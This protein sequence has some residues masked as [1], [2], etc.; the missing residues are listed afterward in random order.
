MKQ[1]IKG[2]RLIEKILFHLEEII[3]ALSRTEKDFV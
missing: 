3:F 1:D 2:I